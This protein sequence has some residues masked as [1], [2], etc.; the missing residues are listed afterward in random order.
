LNVNRALINY[1]ARTNDR[2]C[3][4]ANDHR[5]DTVVIDPVPMALVNGRGCGSTLDKEGFVL[6]KHKSAVGDFTNP[7]A[8]ATL[9]PRE[10]TAL[11]LAQTGA[12]EV[13]VTAPGILR[14]SEKSAISGQLNN[15]TPARFAHIDITPETAAT[16]ASA[17]VPERKSWRRYAHFN[18]WRSFS[19]PP[20]DV[21]LTLCDAQSVSAADLIEADA[22]FDE[23]GKPE[24]SFAGHIVA[25][26]PQHR[27]HWFP[28]MSPEEALI[29]KTSD[30]AFGNAVP[31]VAFDNA[32]A[33]ADCHP[34]ASIEMRAIAFWYA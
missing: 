3:Y 22:I 33:P 13:L 7:D 10:I 34:R 24:W 26:N 17:A 18:V 1:A 29:F 8:V 23:P 12:D 6:V 21:G 5:R 20:Q 2:P 27:W 15:S 19:G 28:D 16:F 25:H 11:L 30:S 14:Y 31:H 4:F 32:L 9:H